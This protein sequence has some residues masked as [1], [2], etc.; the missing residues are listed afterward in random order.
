MMLV[1]RRTVTAQQAD[2]AGGRLRRPQL[3]GK[4]FGASGG[5]TKY[6]HFAANYVT[7]E[8]LERNLYFAEEGFPAK[9]NP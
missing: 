9:R 6:E 7:K 4:T 5:R 3:I 2:E 1:G 8:N